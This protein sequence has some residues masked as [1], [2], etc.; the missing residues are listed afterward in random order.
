MRASLL[1]SFLTLPFLAAAE[2]I[3][4]DTTLA[5][6]K[7]G[8]V[9]YSLQPSGEFSSKSTMK[10]GPTEVD[11]LLKGKWS[12]AKLTSWDLVESANKQTGRIQWNG[13]L[14]QVEAN[15]KVLQKDYKTDWK[16]QAFMSNYHPQLAST[17]LA[18]R[19]S[20]G[21]PEIDV[22]ILNA[23]RPMKMKAD[24]EPV[25][26]TVSGGA[27]Q[28]VKL[29]VTIGNVE[30][31][32]LLLDEQCVGMDVPSQQFRMVRRGYES[33][34]LNPLSKYPELSQP[35]FKTMTETRVKT[36]MRDGIELV[37]DILR[38]VGEGRYPV[39]L[40][41]TPYG[42]STSLLTAGMF[43][44]RGYV[45]V[46]QDVRG[47]GASGGGWDPFNAEVADGKDTLD[48]LVAQPWCDGNVGMIGAS[49]GGLVQWAAAVNHHPA[50]KC[51]IPQVS[52]PEPTRNIPWDNGCF[53]LMSGLWWSRVVMDRQ[54]DMAQVLAPVKN[55]KALQTLPLNKVDEKLLGRDIPFYNDWLKRPNVSDWKGAYTTQQVAG[56]KIP[57][58]HISGVWDGDAVGTMIHYDALKRAGGNQWLIYGPWTHF[59]N[60]STK[61]GGQDY[62][63]GAILELDSAYLRFFDSYLKQKSVG[64]DAQ[65][66]VQFFVTGSNRWVNSQEWPPSGAKQVSYFLGGGKANGAKS[67]GQLGS[68]PSKQDDKIVYNPAKLVVPMDVLDVDPAKATTA[69]GP[70]D[71]DASTLVYRTNPFAADTTLGGPLKADLFV[72]TTAR[73][74]SFH[75]QVLDLAPDGKY[76]LIAMTGNMRVGFRDGK[77]NPIQPYKVYRI[78]VEPWLFAR[79]FKKGH[80]L[81]I[82][83][84]SDMFPGFARVAGTGEPDATA[85]RLVRA[86]NTVHKTAKYPS[87]VN[88]WQIP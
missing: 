24:I 28:A 5:G 71:L 68:A 22:V 76:W 67:Q 88:L 19:A 82:A 45:V 21:K 33:V 83:V 46:S 60:T 10:I 81:A 31:D 61:F 27:Q 84:R 75:V 50:L 8:E 3:F 73:D 32:Y 63:P 25:T 85:T 9:V 30:V 12:G 80:R 44:K 66:R 29:H 26:V 78:S 65:P 49:Y 39:I 74:A 6:S 14:A 69:F 59:F 77:L 37:S 79:T 38:P 58:M 87:K 51:I 35:T 20:T 23:V 53:M 72:S 54:A 11:S 4:F 43:A 16:T 7:V 36:K 41:R 86:V 70:K 15:G 34:F 64:M 18:E 42:R 62:G 52:P 56:V 40:M 47:R 48:W 1:V 17:I 2:D 55:L 57:V 13:R